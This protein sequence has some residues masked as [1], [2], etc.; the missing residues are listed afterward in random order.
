MLITHPTSLSIQDSIKFAF[1]HLSEDEFPARQQLIMNLIENGSIEP[2]GFFVGIDNDIIVG[3]SIAQLR[4]D[5]LIMIWHPVTSDNYTIR[6]FFPL[7]DDYAKSRNAPAV[8]LIADKD[9]F[10]DEKIFFE[11]G[12]TYISD[13]LM[14]AS[15][16]SET[17]TQIA[18]ENLKNNSLL[19]FIPASKDTNKNG[20][21][22]YREHII[23]LM[24]ETY[25][26]TRDFPKLL[27]LSPVD[28]I[29]DEYQR[30]PFFRPELWFFVRKLYGSDKNYKDIGVLLLTDSPPDQIELT[31]MGLVE[32]ERGQKYSKEIIKFTKKTACDYGRKLVTTA[33]DERNIAALRSY[34]NHGFIT[35]DR[36]KI[37][38]KIFE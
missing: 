15:N 11:N 36:K 20:E 30:N 27:M 18:N 32:A 5:G 38:A 35:W 2:D 14:L 24:C 19:Q 28:R 4:H 13:M 37:Y 12:F 10:V 1:R 22:N 31:Y 34:I 6:P 23:K 33:V 7:I 8:I 17:V 29:L 25:V 16:A 26:N 21:K 9:Q 3:V